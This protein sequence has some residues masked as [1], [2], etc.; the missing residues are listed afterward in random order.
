MPPIVCLGEALIDLF[1]EKGASLRDLPALRPSPGGA[2]ANVAVA[3]AR[4]GKAV[5]FIG[6]VG[7]DDFGALLID[8]LAREGVDT[9]YF[10]ADQRA[11][12]ML[13]VVASPSPSEQ[14][15]VLY[16]GADT[17]LRVDEL[18]RAYLESAQLFVH[19][20]VILACESAAAALQAAEWVRAAGRP[21]IFDVNLR[22]S[23]WPDLGQARRLIREAIASASVVKLNEVELEFV[24]GTR[25][26]AQGS[27]QLLAQG[28][29]LCCVSLGARGCYFATDRVNGAVPPF[30]VQVRDTT[31]SGDAFVAGLAARLSELEQPLDEVDERTFRQVFRFANACGALAATDVGGMR[32]LPTRAAVEHL[33]H[34]GAPSS[35]VS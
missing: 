21:V 30:T 3:L 20:S 19:G 16:H 15:F 32:A 6:R 23:L 9:T 33:L 13:A 26:P 24:T 22:P 35:P 1:A 11:P 7:Q 34:S 18:P 2:P 10:V 27:R 12:T 8:L 31:G 17:L 4:L 29:Q 14:R 25:D 5:G 28:V